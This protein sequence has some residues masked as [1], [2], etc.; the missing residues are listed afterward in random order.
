MKCKTVNGRRPAITSLVCA[1]LA[2]AVAPAAFG[3]LDVIA[4]MVAVWKGDVWSGAAGVSRSA[5][6][7][8][9]GYWF[10]GLGG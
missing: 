10:A 2:L 4:G 1:A 7:A 5:V 8:V 6:S 9:V 3:P